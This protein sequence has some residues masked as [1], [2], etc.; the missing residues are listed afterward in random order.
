MSCEL[1]V[2]S[3]AIRDDLYKAFVRKSS[4]HQGL[5]WVGQG[6]VLV[7]AVFNIARVSNHDKLFLGVVG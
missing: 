1:L 2:C 5:V 4:S 3:S 6:L 7:V